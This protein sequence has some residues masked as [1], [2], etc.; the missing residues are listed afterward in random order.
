MSTIDLHH[1]RATPTSQRASFEALAT[2]LFQR[3][4]AA[5][6]GSEFTSLR[7]DGGD[8][9]VEAYFREPSGAVH[10]VQAKY[11][12]KLGASELGQ[13][14][15]SLTTAL[16]NY[17]ELKTYVIYIPFDLTGRR[18]QGT[19]GKSE[20]ERY[21]TWADQAPLPA[22]RSTSVRIELVTLT[23]IRSKL[24]E[25]D[26]H[27][28]LRRYWFTDAVLTEKVIRS[29]LDSA[30]AFAGPRYTETLDVETAAHDALRFFGGTGDV[31]AWIRDHLSR[32]VSA[33]NSLA[34]RMD[35]ACATLASEELEAVKM[36]VA[37]V[38]RELASIAS[39]RPSADAPSLMLAA[40]NALEPLM[41]KTEEL[42]YQSFCERF[43]ADKDTPAFR[44]FQA[45]FMCAFPASNLDVARDAR[46]SLAELDSVLASPAV[47]ATS[48]Q[49]LLLVGPAGVGK[50]H[51]IVSAAEARLALGAYSLVL[52]GDDFDGSSPWEVIRSKL[53]FSATVGREE[54]F[55]CLQACSAALGYPFIIFID[56]LNE[57]PM[58]AKW[59][60][61]LPEFLQQLRGYPRLKICVST[62]D[63]YRDLVVDSRFPG[64]AF[65]HPG[66]RGREFEALQAFAKVYE[67]HAEITPLFTEEASNPL[68][69][70]LACK[71][72]RARGLDA[73]DL[74]LDGFTGLFE[75]YLELC[76]ER[77]RARLQ[78]ASPGPLVRKALLALAAFDG[79]AGSVPWSQACSTIEPLLYGEVKAAVF[80]EELRKEGLLIVTPVSANEYLVRFGYQRYGDVL[81]CI[82]L[83][84]EN[85]SEGRLNL[86]S[87]AAALVGA[88]GG[89]LEALA[90]VLPE[91]QGIEVTEPGLG[92]PTEDA[93][94]LFLR[95]LLWR[96]KTSVSLETEAN[97]RRVLT[98][99]AWPQ[100]FQTTLQLS[101]V[102]EHPLN[103]DW[104]Y[105]QLDWQSP[106]TRDGFFWLALRSSYDDAG[107][108]KSLVDAARLADLSRW[109]KESLRLAAVSLGCLCSSPDR[110]VRDQA[111]KGL[112]R[113]FGADKSL[114]EYVTRLFANCGDEYILESITT[115]IY[116]ACLLEPSQHRRLFVDALTALVNASSYDSPHAVIRNNVRLLPEAIG[117]DTLPTE[118][119]AALSSYPTKVSLPAA[120]PTE[121]EANGLL[122][123][124]GVVVNM[125]F[126]STGLQPDFWRYQAE[127]ELRRFDL[128]KAG[129]KNA[130]VAR[131]L[132]C[133]VLREGYPG[134]DEVCVE[135]DRRLVA[136]VG[137]GRARL[138]YAERLGKKYAWIAL[139]R[140]IGMLSDNLEPKAGWSGDAPDRASLEYALRLRKTDF[141]D[142][143]DI[144]TRPPYPQ[145]LLR[146]AHYPFPKED[147]R[148]WLQRNDLT[149]HADCL[150]RMDAAGVEWFALW[151][152]VSDDDRPIASD[153]YEDSYRHITMA[154]WTVFAPTGF[155]WVAKRDRLESAMQSSPSSY[156]AFFAEY[157]REAAFKYC[158]ANADVYLGERDVVFT[159]LRLLRG[160]EWEYDYSWDGRAPHMYAPAPDLVQKLGLQWDQHSGWQDRF[161][162]LAALCVDEGGNDALFLR[163][164]LL[165]SFL[166]REKLVVYLR[167]FVSRNR[168]GM[169]SN[170]FPMRDEDTLLGYHPTVGVVVLDN[171]DELFESD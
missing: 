33:F 21:Q 24:V 58:G 127:P 66:F 83:I 73:L 90:A 25:L 133:E 142:V 63:T 27:G 36:H 88:D 79:A 110:R 102:P 43:G 8:G 168:V 104:L 1:I 56:A 163:K 46:K 105:E 44:Q 47:Q 61:R 121:E 95:G 68:F 147:N 91:T 16:E 78:F 156:R 30:K 94:G 35:E 143:R 120:W 118:L 26:P 166:A 55:E 89:L 45:E 167:R 50:T 41:A 62:R 126:A 149:P 15:G 22:G 23:E 171:E 67:L 124:K 84:E 13:I 106:A 52:F 53:G 37:V 170:N 148:L 131:W 32:S 38:R 5:P 98:T 64:Y 11:F 49:S 122:Q 34:T 137:H 140:L 111:G 150:V 77:I 128:A 103:A 97:F 138:G 60:D 165:D 136:K 17:P 75:G 2:L 151:L 161:G 18:A 59:K 145:T 107:V 10:G 48:A 72:L 39:G 74:S 146:V 51:A 113:I 159:N 85:S 154:Y 42:N 65:T 116:S 31:S 12:F 29:C 123:Y 70:H 96:S 4:F 132:M 101:L 129:I 20:T 19:A 3:T 14:K 93:A 76:D 99:K 117:R 28:G 114:T 80:L 71:T 125:D 135:Y 57:G 139:N 115:A 92:L 158:V 6:Q 7:G 162:R 134:D 119:I 69:L 157:P 81:R 100:V 152:S 155:D 109:P 86:A 153:L 108:V 9:G 141:T 144:R 40:A 130:D 82:R 164:D 160:G 112:T 169:M 54:L 87:L